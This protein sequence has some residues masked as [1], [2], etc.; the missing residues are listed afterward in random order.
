MERLRIPEDAY[1]PIL[2]F[3]EK[4]SKPEEIARLAVTKKAIE[5]MVKDWKLQKNGD[6]VFFLKKEKIRYKVVATKNGYCVKWIK[7]LGNPENPG[8]TYSFPGEKSSVKGRT[9]LIDY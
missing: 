1:S 6:G 8:K 2:V 5:R 9:I 4:E 7:F 3:L